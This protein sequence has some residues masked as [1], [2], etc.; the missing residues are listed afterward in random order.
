MPGFASLLE[1]IDKK[2]LVLL[3]DN[4]SLFGI[5]RSID[6]FA[7]LVLHQTVE[8][9]YVGYEFGEINRGVFLI[10]GENVAL[11]GEV[12]SVS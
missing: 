10:R 9:I 2:V 11:C 3:R 12:V 8:R 1:Q 6:Q 5:L 7:N 4:R